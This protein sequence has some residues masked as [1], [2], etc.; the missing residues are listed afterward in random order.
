L[1]FI[2]IQIVDLKLAK[3]E[4]AVSSPVFRSKETLPHPCGGV[5]LFGLSAVVY[6]AISTR[7]R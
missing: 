6:A 7:K 2:D 4:V 5:F 3:G 1:L